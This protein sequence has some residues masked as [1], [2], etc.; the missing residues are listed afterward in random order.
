VAQALADLALDASSDSQLRYLAMRRLEEAGQVDLS[1]TV[2]ES[3]AEVPGSE[4]FL[5]NNAIGLLARAAA[6]GR[7]RAGQVLERLR[8]QPEQGQVVAQLEARSAPESAS[9]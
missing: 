4:S 2:A 7:G 9:R 8:Q 3:V 1:I 5:R 6:K